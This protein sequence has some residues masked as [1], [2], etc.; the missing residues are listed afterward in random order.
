MHGFEIS[1]WLERRSD[2]QLKVVDAALL[3][4]LHRM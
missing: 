4:A 1:S 2:S 3:Q